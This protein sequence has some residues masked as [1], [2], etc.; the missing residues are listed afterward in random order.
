M[1]EIPYLRAR[2][3]KEGGLLMLENRLHSLLVT[4]ALMTLLGLPFLVLG[5]ITHPEIVR[6]SLGWFLFVLKI[7]A[8]ILGSCIIPIVMC[9]CIRPGLLSGQVVCK[10]IAKSVLVENFVRNDGTVDT[11]VRF[12]VTLKYRRKFYKVPVDDELFSV[13][14]EDNTMLY[15]IKKLKTN[16]PCVRTYF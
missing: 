4:C 13:L 2:C 16:T 7:L 1:L 9:K 8:I 15:E 12:M 6:A 11:S 3:V 10:I 5:T 14:V